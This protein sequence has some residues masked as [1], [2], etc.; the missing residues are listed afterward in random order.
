[1]FHIPAALNK[2]YRADGKTAARTA[3]SGSAALSEVK[4]WKRENYLP[5]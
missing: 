5:E 2:L 3:V 4:L 1:M